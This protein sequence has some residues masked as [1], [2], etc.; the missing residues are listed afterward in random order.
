MG[1]PKAVESRVIIGVEDMVLLG[2]LSEDSVVA[3]LTERLSHEQI[4][5]NI[6]HVLVACNPFKWLPIYGDDSIKRYVHQQRVD[7]APHIFATSE[8]AYRAM[9]VEEENQCVI[10]SGESGAGKT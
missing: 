6:G 8:A 10:I 2:N 3:N 4:Y 5:T 7:V 9:I 1:K